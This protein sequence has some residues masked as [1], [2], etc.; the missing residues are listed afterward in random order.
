MFSFCD[1]GQQKRRHYV[2]GGYFDN[3]GQETLL[4]ALKIIPFEKY[5]N[6][7]PIIL[8]FNFSEIDTTIGSSIH[9]ANGAFEIAQAIYQA[10][11]ARTELANDALKK[12][13][14]SR[15]SADQYISLSLDIN[16]KKLPMNWA[17]S[18]TAL[19]RVDNFTT[20]L[21]RIKKSHAEMKKL[22]KAF[23]AP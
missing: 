11:N 16:T 9:F 3:S 4:Q 1:T 19:Q 7:K 18:H 14:I 22:Y 2:D 8:C 10:R 5:P 23:T 15:F 17:V 20:D 6:I 12:Y 21:M 13:C